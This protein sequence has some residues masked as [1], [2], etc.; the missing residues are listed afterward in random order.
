MIMT[1]PL[2][3]D[4]PTADGTEAPRTS[5]APRNRTKKLSTVLLVVL[6]VAAVGTAVW[7]TQRARELQQ[8]ADAWETYAT[9]AS[10][11]TTKSTWANAFPDARQVDVC[12]MWDS[13]VLTDANPQTALKAITERMDDFTVR[14]MGTDNFDVLGH[15]DGFAVTVSVGNWRPGGPGP[16]RG[17]LVLVSPDG[18]DLF[19]EDS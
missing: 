5:T 11:L 4:P 17:T 1:S 2:L 3:L 16:I 18:S 6:L 9:A 15:L 19:P 7:Q 12:T 8:R 14:E 10:W 13:C